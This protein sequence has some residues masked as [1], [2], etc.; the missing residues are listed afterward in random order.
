[1]VSMHM[2]LE[3]RARVRQ[4]DRVSKEPDYVTI[5]LT[6]DQIEKPGDLSMISDQRD[7]VHWRA[8]ESDRVLMFNI[9]VW[10]LDP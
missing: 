7:N 3:G 8:A 2:I 10:D 4:F 1:M 9:Q 6:K 5:R